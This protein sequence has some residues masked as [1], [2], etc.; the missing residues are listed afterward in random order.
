MSAHKVLLVDDS[1]SAR[2]ALRLLLKKHDLEVDTA[3]SAEVALEKIKTDL[4]DAIFMDHLMPGMNGFEALETL[5]ADS[6]T[7]HIPVVM[8]TSNDEEHYQRQAREKGALGILSKPADQAKLGEMLSAIEAAM[9]SPETPAAAEP[10][11]AQ[12]AA[13]AATPSTA[14]PEADGAAIAAR[15]K[16]QIHYIL[17]TEVKPYVN[18]TVDSRMEELEAELAERLLSSTAARL[19]E[20]TDSSMNRV[21]EV[22]A[23]A[24]SEASARAVQGQMDGE[25]AKLRDDLVRMETDHAQKV[26]QKI[27]QEIL[28]ELI[29][30]KMD[31]IE[32]QLF[33]QLDAR[34]ED[35]TNQVAD[36]LPRS[37]KFVRLVTETAE[38]AAEHKASA[39]ATA[40]TQQ[41]ADAEE[42]A[43]E[44]TDFFMSSAESTNQR[45]YLLAGAAAAVGVLSSALVYFVG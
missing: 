24:G 38:T 22:A 33:N 34:I 21:S 2:Y 44:M 30:S 29:Q 16:G 14:R 13:S 4:P 40:H 3:E 45:M 41:L 23:Q 12:Q 17:Q 6:R 9:G 32:Q 42:K 10:K 39:I 31:G 15:V 35:F 1:K 5:K 37:G 19:E 26:V 36:E 8:C 43:G 11:P 18:M 27:S 28:P 20:W 7:Q 25:I